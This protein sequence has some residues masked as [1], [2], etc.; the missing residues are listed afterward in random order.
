MTTELRVDRIDGKNPWSRIDIDRPG[1]RFSFVVVSDRTGGA[2]PG[3]FQRGLAVVDLLA[4]SFAIQIGDLIEG[5]VASESALD[6]QWDEVDPATGH[7]R[8]RRS[9]RRLAAKMNNH[10]AAS[11]WMPATPVGDSWWRS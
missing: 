3:V 1:E 9:R 2:Q 8:F 5:Y 10:G 11:S 6:Q 4:P 7:R